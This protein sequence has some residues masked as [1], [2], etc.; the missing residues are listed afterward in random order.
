MIAIIYG[1]VNTF[2]QIIVFES[3]KILEFEYDSESS[4]E[5]RRTIYSSGDWE[6]SYKNK[7]TLLDYGPWKSYCADGRTF[8]GEM[9]EGELYGYREEFNADGD[10]EIGQ[11][12]DEKAIGE[13][14]IVK[15]DGTKETINYG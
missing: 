13:W 1:K 9:Y 8:K 15:K 7:E 4:L 10:W 12:F 2:R 6:I 3:G 14:K 11:C 5:R